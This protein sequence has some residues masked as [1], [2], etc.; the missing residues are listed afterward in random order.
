M[1]WT[2]NGRS[3]RSG[4]VIRPEA[5]LHGVIRKKQD[6]IGGR[7]MPRWGILFE[8]NIMFHENKK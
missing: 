4:L 8:E 2:A 6:H 7:C 3:G 5:G 1:V